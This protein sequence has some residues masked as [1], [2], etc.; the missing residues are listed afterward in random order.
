MA[1]LKQN[2]DNTGEF[3]ETQKGTSGV[4]LPLGNLEM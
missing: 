2:F 1:E 4:L 3:L